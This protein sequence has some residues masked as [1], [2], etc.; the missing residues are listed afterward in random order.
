MQLEVVTSL[1]YFFWG[2]GR[3]REVWGGFS[4]IVFKKSVLIKKSMVAKSI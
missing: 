4:L 2:G 1:A 3:V